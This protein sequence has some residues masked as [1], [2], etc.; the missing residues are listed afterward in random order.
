MAD[1][2]INDANVLVAAV[3]YAGIN[4]SVK[5]Y[6]YFTDSCELCVGDLVV[7]PVGSS[8]LAVAKVVELSPLH[9]ALP[10]LSKDIAYKWI[11]S[12]IDPRY[13][14]DNMPLRSSVEGSGITHTKI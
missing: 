6:S 2:G 9:M 7:V 11:I 5:R 1:L 3:Q 10:S 13:I 12:R 8:G 14:V 4:A